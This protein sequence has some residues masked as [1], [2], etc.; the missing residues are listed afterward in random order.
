MHSKWIYIQKKS[1]F[2]GQNTNQTTSQLREKWPYFF[3]SRETTHDMP[4]H[5]SYS[6]KLVLNTTFNYYIW[7]ET[8]KKKKGKTIQLYGLYDVETFTVHKNQID[9]SIWVLNI[10]SGGIK[11]HL[12]WEI[13]FCL[14]KSRL[15]WY[16]TTNGVKKFK[17]D[18]YAKQIKKSGVRKLTVHHLTFMCY[19]A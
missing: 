7:K 3:N 17:G 1:L 13:H 4:N 5:V 12:L 11:G 15:C 9:N 16:F 14:C 8:Q 10:H 6:Y 18:N 19:I 2:S